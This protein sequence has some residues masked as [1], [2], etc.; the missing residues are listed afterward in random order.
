MALLRIAARIHIRPLFTAPRTTAHGAMTARTFAA[1]AGPRQQWA[2]K[3]DYYKVLGV[4]RD[5][6]ADEIKQAFR[7]NGASRGEDGAKREGGTDP[8]PLA[9]VEQDR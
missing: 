7:A 2:D 5:A 3:P 1:A 9:Y 4:K 8:H 6:S